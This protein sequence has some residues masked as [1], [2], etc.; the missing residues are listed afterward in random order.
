MSIKRKILNLIRKAAGTGYVTADDIK[1]RGGVVGQGCAIYTNKID[2]AHANLLT[3]GDNCTIS[4]ARILLHDASTVRGL[5]YSKVGRITIGNEVF[6][7]ADAIILPNVSI[8]N[9]VIIAAGAVVTK[10]VP[11]NSLV[12]GNPA[13][14]IGTYAY[15]LDRQEVALKESHCYHTHHS[16]R[17]ME[18]LIKMRNDLIEGGFGYENGGKKEK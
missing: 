11:N 4:D 14:V 10:D 12:A 16:K 9:N 18:E 1:R 6:V 7:G 8:G 17:T 5:G 15:Y 13:R 2:L 3:I